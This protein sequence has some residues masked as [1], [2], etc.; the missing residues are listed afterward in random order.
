MR[1][2]R[3]A[4][5]NTSLQCKLACLSLS[6]LT[7]QSIL[8]LS[9][10]QKVANAGEIKF[11]GNCSGNEPLGEVSDLFPADLIFKKPKNFNSP[12]AHFA[13]WRKVLM[14]DFIIQQP[15]RSFHKHFSNIDGD[16]VEKKAPA[17]NFGQGLALRQAVVIRQIQWT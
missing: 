16:S 17:Q 3:V 7:R 2:T 5:F 15:L 12:L 9:A 10:T 14:R 6:G 4:D 1:K 8:Y 13:D 11:L